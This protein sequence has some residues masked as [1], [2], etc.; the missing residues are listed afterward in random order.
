MKQIL[1]LTVVVWLEMMRRKDLY[2]L[3]ILIDHFHILQVVLT[4]HHYFLENL[5]DHFQIL[6]VDLMCQMMI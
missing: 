5:I 2:V 1:T 3:M 4:F 6:Q